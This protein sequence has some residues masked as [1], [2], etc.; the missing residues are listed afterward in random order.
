M[1]RR[2]MLLHRRTAIGAAALAAALTLAGCGGSSGNAEST[3]Q[4]ADLPAAAGA[5]AGAADAAGGTTGAARPTNFN[6][7]DVAFVQGMI[8]HHRQAVEMAKL[9][10]AH[11]KNP[12]VL[13]LAKGIEGAQAPE[14]AKMT[15]WLKAWGEEVPQGTIAEEHHDEGADHMHAAGEADHHD[16]EEAH[17]HVHGGEGGMMTHEQM[18]GLEK[19]K[20]TAFDKAFLAMMVEHHTGAVTSATNAIARGLNPDVKT[21]CRAI[22]KGQTA[23]IVLMKKLL[24]AK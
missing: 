3:A 13:K 10:A 12:Q 16:E 17:P 6:S 21:L 15:G 7:T 14:I 23:E 5:A 24:K 4:S 22:V 19:L 9:A 20:G 18:D 1:N 8:P 2:N 11:T